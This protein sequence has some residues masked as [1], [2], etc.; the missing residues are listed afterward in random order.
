MTTTEILIITGIVLVIVLFTILMIILLRNS[1]A[2]TSEIKGRHQQ[3]I[4]SKIEHLQT[5]FKAEI[6][7]QNLQSKT[8][9]EKTFMSFK[10]ARSEEHTSELQSRP[11]LVCRLLLEKK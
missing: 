11:H 7:K 3:E 2:P 6:E 9:I 8:D 10:E 4:L 5:A 1:K